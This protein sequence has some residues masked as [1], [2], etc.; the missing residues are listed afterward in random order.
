MYIKLGVAI[1][2]IKNNSFQKNVF[3]TFLHESSIQQI[4]V[5]RMF[6][7]LTLKSGK[8]ERERERAA[9]VYELKLSKLSFLGK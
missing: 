5:M 6:L 1:F 2:K 9:S 8:R 7:T 4:S 3:L